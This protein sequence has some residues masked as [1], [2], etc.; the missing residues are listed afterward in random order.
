MR[1]VGEIYQAG[2]RH[3]F[4]RERIDYRLSD[5]IE[6]GT[7][8]P[9]GARNE[10]VQLLVARVYVVELHRRGHRLEARALDR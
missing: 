1:E 3:L 7:I 5:P 6:Y 4:G 10:A 2:N 8:G 9:V